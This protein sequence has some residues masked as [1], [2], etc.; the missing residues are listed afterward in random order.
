M[1]LTINKITQ[2]HTHKPTIQLSCFPLR[3]EIGWEGVEQIHLAEN[4]DLL[5]AVVSTVINPEILASQSL[6]SRV[7]CFSCLVLIPFS[8]VSAFFCPCACSA[9]T[10]IGECHARTGVACT[11]S[12]AVRNALDGIFRF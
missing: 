6:L 1:L 3:E 2:C 4:R 8:A 11:F 12:V 9:C 5:W 10:R 7:V